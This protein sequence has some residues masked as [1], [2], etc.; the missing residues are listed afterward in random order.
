MISVIWTKKIIKLSEKEIQKIERVN[1]SIADKLDAEAKL[2]SQK[3]YRI[4]FERASREALPF[5]VYVIY[6][7]AVALVVL[8]R[9]LEYTVERLWIGGFLLFVIMVAPLFVLPHESWK[10]LFGRLK[11]K[12]TKSSN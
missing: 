9:L 4:L 10:K 2:E 1:R 11:S 12:L 7:G 3:K 6:M 8:F 5:I